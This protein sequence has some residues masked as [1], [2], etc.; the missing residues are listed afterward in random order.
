MKDSIRYF[1]SSIQLG[2]FGMFFMFIEQFQSLWTLIPV[3]KCSFPSDN[4]RLLTEMKALFGECT[5]R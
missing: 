5:Q 4:S 2:D 1:A 3:S